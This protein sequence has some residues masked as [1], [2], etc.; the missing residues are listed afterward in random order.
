MSDIPTVK[1]TIAP[2]ATIT[3]VDIVD[4]FQCYGPL[5]PISMSLELRGDDG[6]RMCFHDQP[7]RPVCIGERVA[8]ELDFPPEVT[9]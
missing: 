1:I 8:V 7:F 3:G 5:V 4:A 2:N 9:E 6:S